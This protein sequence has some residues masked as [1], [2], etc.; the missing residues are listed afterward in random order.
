MSSQL[1]IHQAAQSPARV[2][3]LIT[4]LSLTAALLRRDRRVLILRLP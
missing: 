4:S 1:R 3:L 2:A